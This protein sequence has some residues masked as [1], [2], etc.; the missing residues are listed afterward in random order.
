LLGALWIAFAGVRVPRLRSARNKI[1][2]LLAGAIILQ[3]VIDL[4]VPQIDKVAHLAGAASG[5]V[6]GWLLKPRR[7]E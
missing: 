7:R 1:C 2:I 6:L 3:A 4:N 5:V